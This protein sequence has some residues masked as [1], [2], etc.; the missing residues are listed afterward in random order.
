VK[1]HAEDRTQRTLGECFLI[2]AWVSHDLIWLRC[3]SNVRINY[4]EQ[5]TSKQ[6][7][8]ADIYSSCHDLYNSSVRFAE[9]KP[10]L[11]HQK[12]KWMYLEMN[13]ALTTQP[14]V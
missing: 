11:D 8:M 6:D 10:R 5:Q 1:A 7:G 4:A 3:P 9:V 12:Y 2:D 13:R 14:C